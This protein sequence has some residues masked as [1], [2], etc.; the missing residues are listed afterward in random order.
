MCCLTAVCLFQ[1]KTIIIIICQ[2]DSV[3]INFCGKNKRINT[4]SRFSVK[5]G[6]ACSQPTPKKQDKYIN[7]LQ[8]GKPL[9][10][11][12]IQLPTAAMEIPL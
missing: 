3:T 4:M 11:F 1:I 2:Q 9:M 7:Q 12:P 10:E 6:G 5:G 8:T